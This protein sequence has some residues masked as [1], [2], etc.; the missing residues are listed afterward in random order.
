M[1]ENHEQESGRKKSGQERTCQDPERKEGG[2]E[3]KEG[4]K[5]AT[6]ISFLVA[7]ARAGRYRID[8]LGFL[9]AKY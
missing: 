6:A 4:R 2:E 3:S 1:K 5:K 9:R 7:W 8:S